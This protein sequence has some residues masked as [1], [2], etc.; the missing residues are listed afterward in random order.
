MQTTPEYAENLSSID[1][2]DS[3]PTLTLENEKNE[4]IQIADLASENGVVLFLVPK[5]D[6]R[7]DIFSVY[8]PG[9]PTDMLVP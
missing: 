1:I 6:T 7:K 4:D 3:L 9:C 5:A 2:G 8:K